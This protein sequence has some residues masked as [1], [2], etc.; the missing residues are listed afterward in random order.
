M[1]NYLMVGAGGTGT[2]LLRPLYT[3]LRN[4]H[5]EGDWMLFILDGDVVEEKNLERQ[6]FPP[7]A[8]TTN[9]ARQRSD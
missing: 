7:A 8:V 2:F 1:H 3:Y 4:K 6:A 5:P 9:R